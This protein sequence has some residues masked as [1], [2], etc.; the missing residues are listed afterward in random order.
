MMQEMYEWYMTLD[1]EDV[2]FAR[3]LVR[4]VPDSLQEFKERRVATGTMPSMMNPEQYL[5][6]SFD[7]SRYSGASHG[8]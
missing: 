3:K 4:V 8:S 6:W 7:R 5:S 2:Q 1:D